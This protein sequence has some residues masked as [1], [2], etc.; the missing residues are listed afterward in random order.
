MV[1]QMVRALSAARD[2]ISGRLV[3]KLVFLFTSIIILVVVSLTVI[4]Y[5]MIEKESV[6]SNIESTSNNLLLVNQ[7]LENYLSGIEQLSLPQIQY[8]ELIRAVVNEQTDYS[9][10]MYLENYLRN[11]YFSRMDLDAIYLYLIG[12]QKYYSITREA[13]NITVRVISD[14]HIPAQPWYKEAMGSTKNRSFQSL[15]VPGVQADYPVD[16]KSSFMGYHRVLRSIATRDAK[17]VISL[18]FNSTVKDEIL[19]QVPMGEGEHLLFLDTRHVPFHMDQK[20]YYERVR[21][22]KLMDRVGQSSGGRMTWSD[23]GQ[24]HLVV[25]NVGEQLGWS[26]VKLIPYSKIYEAAIITRNLSY[27]IGLGFLVLSVILVV[28]TSNAITQPIKRLSYQMSRFSAGSFDASA[29]VEGRDEIAYL[30]RHFNQ[31][32]K[33]TNELINERYKLKLTEKNALLKALEAEI[34][35][36]FL[37]NALQAISTKSLKSERF[38]IA[39][40]IDALALTLRYCISGKDIVSAQEELKHIE[41]YLALQK[42]RFGGRLQVDI[43]WEESLLELPIPKLSVQ[44]LVENSIKH[45]LEEVSHDIHIVIR[46][47]YQLEHAAI[48]VTD[49]GPGI[50]PEK[51]EHILN[52]FQTEWEERETEKIGLKNLYTR[53]KLLYGDTAE[54]TIQTDESGTKMCM[55]IPRGGIRHV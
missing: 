39:D 50:A 16:P 5:K 13:Y 30:T 1:K 47:N 24:R 45:A 36:H 33:R 4:S 22:A 42:A 43:E 49:N 28:L 29:K 37:Y 2:F 31:M 10:R 15:A 27:M 12:Q 38:D 54:L 53:L 26:L 46:A 7:N 18:Y 34:N 25:Y 9:A 48:S 35:P 11:L 41:R 55:F 3:N 17:A 52:S 40:M 14:P 44:S 23:G 19:K 8:D 21:D 6:N 20:G 51:L 32:V